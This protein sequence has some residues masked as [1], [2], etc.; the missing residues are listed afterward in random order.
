MPTAGREV[1]QW[2]LLHTADGSI[3]WYKDFKKQ[4]VFLFFNI[5]TTYDPGKLF[6]SIY[7]KETLLMCTP[8]DMCKYVHSA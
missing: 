6:L 2:E 8:E 3:N 5:C 1:C 4:F 7:P